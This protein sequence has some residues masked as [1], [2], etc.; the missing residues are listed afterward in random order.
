[1]LIG[2]EIGDQIREAR[3]RLG[4]SQRALAD[5]VGVDKSAVA[6]WEGGG[7]GKGIKT[8]NLIEV[9]RVLQ[10]RPSQLL[11]EPTD[12]DRM[13]LTDTREMTVITLYRRLDESLKQVHLQLLYA[14]TGASPPPEQKSGPGN[15]KRIGT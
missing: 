1:M 4:L 12:A 15:R 9:A 2:M 3:R 13:E 6:Q 5:K 7:G 10:V 8:D 14:Q 11:G